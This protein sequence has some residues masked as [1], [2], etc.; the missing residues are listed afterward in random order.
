MSDFGEHTQGT[1]T[2]YTQ[3]SSGAQTTNVMLSRE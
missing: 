3:D 2:P 1:T